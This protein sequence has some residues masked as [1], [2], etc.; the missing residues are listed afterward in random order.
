MWPFRSSKRSVPL[1]RRGEQLARRLCRRRGLKILADNYR[2][3]AGEIDLIALD[4]SARGPTGLE[5]IVFIEVKTRRSDRYTS[6]ASAVDS[7]KRR[8]IRRA[9]S[10]YLAHRDARD[11]PTRFDVVAVVI[12][13]GCPPQVTYHQDAFGAS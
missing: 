7:A 8:R 5:T 12:P 1:G 6:P 10:Y 2:C 3:P 11:Y 9:A 13:D 4:P